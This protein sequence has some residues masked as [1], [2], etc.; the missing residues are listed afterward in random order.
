MGLVGQRTNLQGGVVYCLASTAH[1]RAA[2][3][4]SLPAKLG[5]QLPAAPANLGPWPT[6]RWLQG[7]VHGVARPTHE[8][9]RHV[10]RVPGY[11]EDALAGP[12]SFGGSSGRCGQGLMGKVPSLVFEME[13]EDQAHQHPDGAEDG[14]ATEVVQ[15]LQALLEPWSEA[16]YMVRARGGEGPGGGGWGEV[17]GE[18]WKP[19]QD[20]C[21]TSRCWY[22]H[23]S[24]HLPF[25]LVSTP[26][27]HLH[28][29][30]S[31]PPSIPTLSA[32]PSPP[33]PA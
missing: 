1:C 16:E 27:P 7:H 25:P 5:R 8:M 9:V 30:I 12:L 3:L 2:A 10:H 6:F 11:P 17:R 13:D 21:G 29:L 28:P 14:D 18:Q 22:S 32:L 19:L 15:K 24:H 4:S 26:P 33:P 23:G 20:A 31:W